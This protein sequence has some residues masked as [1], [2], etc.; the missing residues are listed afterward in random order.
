MK[1]TQSSFFI[2]KLLF[3]AFIILTSP[4]QLTHAQNPEW[5]IVYN[6][7]LQHITFTDAFNGYASGPRTIVKTTDGGYTWTQLNIN[8]LTFFTT[9]IIFINSQT[10]FVFAEQWTF[11][12]TDAGQS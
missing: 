5:K 10:G 7:G 6:G 11:R 2:A 9:D 4:T 1:Y 12:T 8:N 3:A